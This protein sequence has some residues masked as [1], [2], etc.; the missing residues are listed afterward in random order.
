MSKKI[1]FDHK[2]IIKAGATPKLIKSASESN[3]T[4]KFEA[5]CPKCKCGLK[6]N[7][8]ENT[9]ICQCNKCSYI[10]DTGVVI[11]GSGL[12]DKNL[13]RIKYIYDDIYM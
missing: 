7:R 13:K 5:I 2:Y 6:Y 11:L 1:D 10:P 12:S 4:P 9:L 8:K 3:S